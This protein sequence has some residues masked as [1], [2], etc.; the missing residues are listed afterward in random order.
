MK[1]EKIIPQLSKS[2]VFLVKLGFAAL[3][4]SLIGLYLFGDYI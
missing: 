4:M 3:G 2:K 1:A